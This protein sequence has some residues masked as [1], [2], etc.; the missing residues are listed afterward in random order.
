MKRTGRIAM[1][2]A[3]ALGLA[4]LAYAG[5]GAK[6][7]TLTGNIACAHCTLKLEGVKECQ[8]VLVVDGKDGGNYFLVKNDALKQF[9]H[10]CQG[11]K[12]AKV[13][14]TVA[15]KDGKMWLT[16]SKVEKAEG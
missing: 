3:F 1:V 2:V 12:A 15:T 10:T 13:T 11:Q 8:D 14:G 4:F 9:G 6:E 7:V 16:A 5:E